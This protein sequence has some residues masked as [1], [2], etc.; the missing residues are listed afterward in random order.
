MN[1]AAFP[2]TPHPADSAGDAT[3]TADWRQTADV[4]GPPEGRTIVLVHGVAF[5][6]K[7]WGPQVDDLA[8]AFRV[9]APDLPGHGVLRHVPFRMETAVEHLRRVIDAGAGGRALVVGLSLGGVVALELAHRHPERALGLVLSGASTDYR[10]PWLRALGL[11]N[12]LLLAKIYPERWLVGMQEKALPGLIGPDLA[13]TQIEAG[14]SFRSGAPAFRELGRIDYLGHLGTYPGPTLILNGE[15]DAM[16]RQGERD[17]LR[18]ARDGRLEIV[19]GAG[20]GANLE[21]PAE[22]GIAVRGFAE[23]IAWR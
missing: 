12:W 10:R 6:R 4:A 9:I 5:T 3:A 21:R 13:R 17:F 11:I 14:F 16:N 7:M 15:N 22:F 19:K 8:D 1:H 18:A 2:P 20:H 23:S